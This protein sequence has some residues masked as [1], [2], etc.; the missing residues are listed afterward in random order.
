MTSPVPSFTCC[1]SSATPGFEQETKVWKKKSGKSKANVASAHEKIW[2]PTHLNSVLF[3][4]K[5]RTWEE[6]PAAWTQQINIK[7]L[8]WECVEQP[9]SWVLNQGWLLWTFSARTGCTNPHRNSPKLP[10]NEEK[11]S[12]DY[13]LTR[14]TN[15][16]LQNLVSLQKTGLC[17]R[18][19]SAFTKHFI[20]TKQ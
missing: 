14:G 2:F 5:A 16:N 17:R 20:D 11:H 3:H 18:D 15:T 19:V 10:Q 7:L 4:F 9:L 12:R 1:F 8:N 13:F 6:H